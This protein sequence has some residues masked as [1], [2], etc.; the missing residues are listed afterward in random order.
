MEQDFKKRD[1]SCD[2]ACK[3]LGKLISV[4]QETT[5]LIREQISKNGVQYFFENLEN[6]GF[7][8]DNLEILESIRLVLIGMGDLKPL[9]VREE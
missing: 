3:S 4:D 2:E 6:F 8:P 1:S 7:S 5:R 9:D